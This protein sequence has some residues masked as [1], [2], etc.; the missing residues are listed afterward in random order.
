MQASTFPVDEGWRMFQDRN[1]RK[2][3]CANDSCEVS[4][5]ILQ[6]QG[7]GQCA[8]GAEVLVSYG[9]LVLPPNCVLP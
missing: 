2:Y 4:I 5:I 1:G 6:E 3:K 8:E 9:T 7:T